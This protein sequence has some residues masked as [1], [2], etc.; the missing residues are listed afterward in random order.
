M[1]ICL[2]NPA[3]RADRSY[4]LK[5]KA[6]NFSQEL[7][8]AQIW[9]LA[10]CLAAGNV[11]GNHLAES[12]ALRLQALKFLDSLK[13]LLDVLRSQAR[14]DPMNVN[15]D[16]IR[17]FLR[18][19]DK[20][21][22]EFEL[23]I[24]SVVSHLKKVKSV[25]EYERQQNI[26]VL[27]SESMIRAQK[28]KYFTVEQI[29]AC[30][31]ALIFALPRLSLTWG[32]L[33]NKDNNKTLINITG[34]SEDLTELFSKYHR[35]LIFV[36]HL[37]QSLD[38]KQLKKLELLTGVVKLDEIGQFLQQNN[39]CAKKRIFNQFPVNQPKKDELV[40]ELFLSICGIADKLH[41]EHPFEFSHFI[42]VSLTLP[43]SAPECEVLNTTVAPMLLST[44]SA[45]PP[46]NTYYSTH[47]T[48]TI[49]RTT[50]ELFSK[51]KCMKC[52]KCQINF[53]LL[54]QKHRCHNC[55]NVFCSTCCS[56]KML[57]T[58]MNRQIKVR[59]CDECCSAPS[60]I[61]RETSF[62]TAAVNSY[63]RNS[64]SDDTLSISS[65]PNYFV[66]PSFNGYNEI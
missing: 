16:L 60:A 3:E 12:A 15:T 65:T 20:I 28:L 55:K 49:N 7:F 18:A 44:S 10:E 45:T 5:F 59:L 9:F 58:E 8:P 37:L 2:P 41:S 46:S 47:L 21:F 53:C 4:R 57:L 33:D 66:N 13:K 14:V 50:S 1:L 64:Y 24:F 61:L 11:I 62:Y 32:L 54:R 27:F 22:V 56:N 6:Q 35:Q 25:K 19:F 29:E 52:F 63:A 40:Q 30:D 48:S 17:C 36:K 31:P 38:K 42:K 39:E 34:D 23:N 43:S 26:A 51:W